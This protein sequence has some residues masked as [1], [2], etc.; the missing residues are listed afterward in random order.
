MKENWSYRQTQ[1]PVPLSP[2]LPSYSKLN[3]LEIP[4]LYCHYTEITDRHN[5]E[6]KLVPLMVFGS[7]K[8]MSTGLLGWFLRF[9]ESEALQRRF[10]APWRWPGQLLASSG[11]YSWSV[12][13]RLL[14]Q[15][16]P[17][18][19]ETAGNILEAALPASLQSSVLVSNRNSTDPGVL[20][21]A[22][23]QALCKQDNCIISLSLPFGI[24]VCIQLPIL[25]IVLP[26][27][28]CQKWCDAALPG[29]SIR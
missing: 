9:C 24:S 7:M 23:W 25:M 4:A 11:L 12:S 3:F 13:K 14:K 2:L 20:P 26:L 6:G 10:F 21:F 29:L 5:Q 27:E 15:S 28:N 19:K 17:L 8:N 22:M 1:T 16:L 18:L